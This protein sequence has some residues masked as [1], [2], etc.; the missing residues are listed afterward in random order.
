MYRGSAHFT[1]MQIAIIV[2]NGLNNC[3]LMAT[4]CDVE[5]ET[6]VQVIIPLVR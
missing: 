5:K 6:C 2:L 1:L 4:I 3:L